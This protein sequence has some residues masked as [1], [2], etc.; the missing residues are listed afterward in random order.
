MADPYVVPDSGNELEDTELA[1]AIRLSLQ[2]VDPQSRF[3]GGRGGGRG[4]GESSVA[5]RR[6]GGGKRKAEAIVISDTESETEMYKPPSRKTQEAIHDSPAR[7]TYIS[8]PKV[9]DSVVYKSGPVDTETIEDE[10]KPKISFLG[11][12]RRQMERERLERLDRLRSENFPTAHYA[13]IQKI[14]AIMPNIKTRPSP[15]GTPHNVPMVSRI[16]INAFRSDPPAP[17]IGQTYFTPGIKFPQGVV[18]KTW[19]KDVPRDGT[20]ITIEEV[21]QGETLYGAVL[22]AFQWDLEWLWTKI[23]D[24]KLQRLVLVMQ[25]KEE[26]DKKAVLDVLGGLPKTSIVFPPMENVSCMHS[27]LM[28]LF[29]RK[30]DTKEEWLR[31]AVPSANLVDYDWGER[32]TME[33]V[34]I[35]PPPQSKHPLTHLRPSS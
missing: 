24:R 6:G 10:K 16:N 26:S 29:H 20:D 28:L 22:S 14:Q 35:L 23:P 1:L 32:G 13:T 9:I 25:A 17:S 11:I 27:K 5:G 3:G 30:P 19:A 33:N 34:H 8:T 18:K 2:E 21:L 7:R 31:I 4:G 15:P 12:D